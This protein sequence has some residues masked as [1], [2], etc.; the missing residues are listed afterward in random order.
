[1]SL[2]SGIR[3]LVLGLVLGSA[4]L[5]G[6]IVTWG[7]RALVEERDREGLETLVRGRAERTG[8]ALEEI[9]RDARQIAALPSVVDVLAEHRSG[10]RGAAPSAARA[11]LLHELEALLVAHP[12]YRQARLLDAAGL[13]LARL[14]RGDDGLRSVPPEELQDKGDRDYVHEGLRVRAP[15]VSLSAV[16]PNRERGAIEVPHAPMLRAGL[17]VDDASGAPA[18]LVVLNVAFRMFLEP[19]FLYDLG[20]ARVFV[21]DEQGDFLLHPDPARAHRSDLGFRYR[22]ADEFPELAG[23]TIDPELGL[24]IRAAP[25]PARPAELVHFRRVPTSGARALLVG[26]AARDVGLGARVER[27][28]TYALAA[29]GALLCVALL[30]GYRLAAR[31]TQPLEEISVAAGTIAAGGEAPHLPVERPGEAGAVAR[32]LQRMLDALERNARRLRAAN[33]DLEH[34]AHV[35]SHDLREPARRVVGLTD[36]LALQEEGRLSAG[37]AGLIA[38]VQAE[39]GAMLAQI[40][41]LRVL[42]GIGDAAMVRSE[43]D[44]EALVARVLDG[45]REELEARGAAVEVGTLGSV[46]AY[47]G[48]LEPLYANLVANAL[49]HSQGPLRLRFTREEEPAGPRLGVA[50]TG[51]AIP[52]DRL[53]AIFEPFTKL[54]ATRRPGLGLS[55]CKRI[56]ERHGGT[57]VA[58]S[59]GSW[60]R[61]LFTL[62]PRP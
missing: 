23:M 57:I 5:V 12:E 38:R 32:A 11:Q 3:W 62:G 15:A 6:A 24:T 8:L 20:S 33:A 21:T 27:V 55:I 7:F 44:L 51:S 30:V 56:V 50:N 46:E 43:V 52:A 16:T 42:V 41:D 9:R 19:L 35:A 10:V 61:F 60:T 28:V 14:D 22:L 13:E 2:S 36:L 29:T 4:L 49:Q 25:T 40:S 54:R 18:G 53:V 45:A 1:M 17:V 59:D 37:G 58:A 39:A 31:I 48:L 34:F 47:E 26:V